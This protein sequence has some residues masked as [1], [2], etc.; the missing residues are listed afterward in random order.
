[1][2]NIIYPKNPALFNKRGTTAAQGTRAQSPIRT[3]HTPSNANNADR[4]Q[5]FSA[6]PPIMHRKDMLSY[7]NAFSNQHQTT[8]SFLSQ[9][10]KSSKEEKLTFMKD[11]CKK[12]QIFFNEGDRIN[13]IS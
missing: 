4:A 2:K 12:E 6:G 11:F 13:F 9:R 5:I 10:R 3:S 8:A 1:M 7:S